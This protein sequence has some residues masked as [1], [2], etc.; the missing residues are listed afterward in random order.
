MGTVRSRSAQELLLTGQLRRFVAAHEAGHAALGVVLGLKVVEVSCSPQ[1]WGE[2]Q[3]AGG[4]TRFLTS[5][6][7]QE[8]LVADHPEVAGLVLLA[9]CFAEQS[10][11]DGQF[12]NGG[13]SGDLEV[14]KRGMMRAGLDHTSREQA[15]ELVAATQRHV[16]TNL[17]AIRTIAQALEEAGQ[18]TGAEVSALLGLSR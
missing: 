10:L 8:T 3:L 18:L 1:P 12:V 11:L 2:G 17:D 16:E 5:N 14:W 9:G 4:G 6:G 15:S 13:F 7:A